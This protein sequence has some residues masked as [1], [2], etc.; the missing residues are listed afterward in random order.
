M[1][2]KLL[3]QLLQKE[4]FAPNL[5]KIGQHVDRTYIVINKGLNKPQ[6]PGFSEQSGCMF[7]HPRS[8]F[9]HNGH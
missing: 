3:V 8:G 5:K 6:E 1:A 9:Y 7:P 2:K 4:T